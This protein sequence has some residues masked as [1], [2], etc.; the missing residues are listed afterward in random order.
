MGAIA[1]AI[2]VLIDEVG[3]GDPQFRDGKVNSGRKNSG[4]VVLCIRLVNDKYVMINFMKGKIAMIGEKGNPEYYNI[5]GEEW[6]NHYALSMTLG[7]PIHS[8]SAMR[9]DNPYRNTS[10]IIYACEKIL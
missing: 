10:C 5:R 6:T 2:N 9:L 3:V 7:R 4:T 1:S 8:Y